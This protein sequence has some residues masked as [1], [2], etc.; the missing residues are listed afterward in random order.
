MCKED[1]V[2]ISLRNQS[3]SS[4]PINHELNKIVNGEEEEDSLSYD[5]SIDSDSGN[6]EDWNEEEHH[7]ESV[8]TDK[9]IMG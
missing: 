6:K 9:R 5:S 4:F 1:N 7:F 2:H 8:R 3:L